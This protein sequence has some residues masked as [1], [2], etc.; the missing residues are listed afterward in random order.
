MMGQRQSQEK[1]ES[2]Y[3]AKQ[4]DRQTDNEFSNVTTS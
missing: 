1:K 3:M 4:T 2:N